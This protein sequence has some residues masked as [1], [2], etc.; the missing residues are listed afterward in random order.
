M[1]QKLLKVVQE[2]TG[3]KD[4]KEALGEILKNYVNERIAVCREKIQRF[5]EKYKMSFEEFHEK[6]GEDLAL[7]WEHESDAFDWEGALTDLEKLQKLKE[8]YGLGDV[9]RKGRESS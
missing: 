3:K 8:R 1:S 5:Q 6:L 7:S 4:E 9:S 2:V